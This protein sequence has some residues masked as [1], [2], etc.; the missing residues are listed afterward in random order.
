MA[1]VSLAHLGSGWNEHVDLS[2]LG[3]Y[4]CDEHFDMVPEI[5]QSCMLFQ[6]KHSVTKYGQVLQEE[7]VELLDPSHFPYVRDAKEGLLSMEIQAGTYSFL[8]SCARLILHDIKPSMLFFTAAHQ[9]E[10]SVEHFAGPEYH[11]LTGHSLEAPY[12]VPQALDLERLI[13]L[14]SGRRSSAEDHIWTLKEDRKHARPSLSP[15]R[16]GVC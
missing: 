13:V 1:D 10:P 9:P 16:K 15:H 11:S 7:D 8:L 12:R 3:G 6:S 4:C 14:V 5:P 2:A